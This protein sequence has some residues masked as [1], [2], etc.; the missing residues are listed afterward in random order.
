MDL[1]ASL[2]DIVG[3]YTSH[4][5]EKALCVLR[6]LMCSL[7]L[8][9]LDIDITGSRYPK[10]RRTRHQ[11]LSNPIYSLLV[12]TFSYGFERDTVAQPISISES[13]ESSIKLLLYTSR[14]PEGLPWTTLG[15]IHP[16]EYLDFVP[17]IYIAA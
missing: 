16:S 3:C 8:E 9:S 2:P 4:S 15:D 7:D 11:R 17:G 14:P 1:G 5:F 12:R 10:S 13:S 6:P